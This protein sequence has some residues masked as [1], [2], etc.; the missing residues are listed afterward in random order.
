[1]TARPRSPTGTG[2]APC[3]ECG[4]ELGVAPENGYRRSAIDP[5][6][7]QGRG[8]ERSLGLKAPGRDGGRPIEK[9]ENRP[10]VDRPGQYG[11]GG[12]HDQRRHS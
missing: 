7:P 12:R 9:E 10:L 2:L 6:L 11:L 1:M 5:G 8:Q 4:V 3:P